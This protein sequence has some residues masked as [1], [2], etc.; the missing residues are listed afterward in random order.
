[1]PYYNFPNITQPVDLLTT[2]NSFVR[3]GGNTG[4][5]VFGFLIMI[6]AYVILFIGFKNYPTETAFAGASYITTVI[7]LFLSVMGL[8]SP[9]FIVIMVAVTAISTVFLMFRTDKSRF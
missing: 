3:V 4:E 1:M 2:V 8:L 6:A 7:A 9:T 5:P